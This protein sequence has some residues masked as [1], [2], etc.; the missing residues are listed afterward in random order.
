MSYSLD[1]LKILEEDTT[2]D[3]NSFTPLISLPAELYGKQYRKRIRHPFPENGKWREE[4]ELNGESVVK[5][6]KYLFHN[7]IEKQT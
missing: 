6:K 3:P 5:W 7:Y 4:V 2:D 1:D